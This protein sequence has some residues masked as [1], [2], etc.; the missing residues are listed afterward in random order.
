MCNEEIAPALE[1]IGKN[2]QLLNGAVSGL[3]IVLRQAEQL[4]CKKVSGAVPFMGLIW[5]YG[6]AMR[7]VLHAKRQDG[8]SLWNA[9]ALAVL[10]RSLQEAFISMFYFAIEKTEDDES[11]FRQ[12]LLARH[13]AYKRW[14]L[15]RRADQENETIAQEC[16]SALSEWEKLGHAVSS[17]QFMVKVAPK[18]VKDLL[19]NGEDYIIDPLDAVW[20]RAGLPRDMYDVTFR[21]LSQYTHATPYALASLRFHQAGHEDGAV[22]MSIPVGL[23][24][25]CVVK[26]LGYAGELHPELNELLP[27][28]FFEYAKA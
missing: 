11:E 10:C 13:T 3:E 8:N 6:S 19:K 4:D 27:P 5:L 1:R 17:H 15:L 24:L 2:I 20:E 9:P 21:Y 18:V 25:A 16:A 14:D 23:A 28:A 22:N 7:D 12:L 26:T